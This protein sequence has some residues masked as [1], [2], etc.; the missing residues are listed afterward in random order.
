MMW[1]DFQQLS[2]AVAGC[3]Q[4]H[5]KSSKLCVGT[6]QKISYSEKWSSTS[7]S[8]ISQ[9]NWTHFTRNE[10]ENSRQS[11]IKSFSCPDSKMVWVYTS[12]TFFCHDSNTR[13]RHRVT[14]G[15]LERRDA[16]HFAQGDRGKLST[17]IWNLKHLSIKKHQ[18]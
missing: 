18:N 14:G 3:W 12:L 11:T 15:L 2:V 1:A 13:F 9:K 7:K 6:Q 5:W 8:R 10:I 17:R 4:S 16:E